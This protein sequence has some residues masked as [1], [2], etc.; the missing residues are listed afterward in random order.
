MRDYVKVT[1]LVEML[2]LGR[3][4]CW[5]NRSFT[6]SGK[7]ATLLQRIKRSEVRPLD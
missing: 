2:K 4:K 7:H 6:P 5:A 3:G 1:V